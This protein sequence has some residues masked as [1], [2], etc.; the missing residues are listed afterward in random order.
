MYMFILILIKNIIFFYSNWD[1]APLAVGTLHKLRTLHIG[2]GSTA[3]CAAKRQ[4]NE[5]ERGKMKAAN[6]LMLVNCFTI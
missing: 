5:R 4:I 2:S 3:E 1:V 6:Q